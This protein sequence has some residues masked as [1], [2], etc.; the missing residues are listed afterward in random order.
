MRLAH[1]GDE[2]LVGQTLDGRY[3]VTEELGRGGMGVVY[4]ARQKYLDRDLALKVLR[5]S[6]L[7][8]PNNAQ[9]FLQEARAVSRLS[10]PHTVT[11]YDFGVS[12]DGRLYFTMELLEGETVGALIGREGPLDYKT[13]VALTSQA[14]DSLAEAHAQGIWHRDLKPDNMFLTLDPE[15]EVRLKILDFGLARLEG[16]PQVA[17]TAGVVRGTAQYLSPEQALSGRIDGRSDIY[18]LAVTLYEM[19]TGEPPF[20]GETPLA[21]CNSH[22]TRSP[23]AIAEKRPELTLPD[24]L[25]RTVMLALEKDPEGRPQ[26]VREFAGALS[27]SIGCT[28]PDTGPIATVSLPPPPAREETPAQTWQPVFR[29]SLRLCMESLENITGSGKRRPVLRALCWG[30]LGLAIVIGAMLSLEV[31][32]PVTKKDPGRKAAAITHAEPQQDAA[33]PKPPAKKRN[34]GRPKVVA[35]QSKETDS[36]A[37]PPAT[38]H[39]RATVKTTAIN[40]SAR[41]KPVQQEAVAVWAGWRTLMPPE[42]SVGVATDVPAATADEDA[43]TPTEKAVDRRTTS[44][45]TPLE[46]ALPTPVD[47]V[48]VPTAEST[49]EYTLIPHTPPTKL[50]GGASDMTV[51]ATDAETEQVGDYTKLPIAPQSA[52]KNRW[53][54]PAHDGIVQ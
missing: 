29:R 22:L 28:L 19:L 32:T 52:S 45:E 18:S 7:D 49:S 50:K 47:E 51:L 10:N 43:P 13:A 35:S 15:G 21:I 25:C 11:V 46:I 44:P 5:R 42:Q 54:A 3:E 8:D 40:A 23:P 24:A 16:A 38:Q 27:A 36:S 17:T 12:E 4:R 30:A 41:Q 37:V 20:M 6:L 53:T 48:P 1:L 34:R 2:T 33:R 14:C 31:D 39:P 9:R 26:T